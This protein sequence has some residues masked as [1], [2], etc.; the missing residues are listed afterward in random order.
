[1]VVATCLEYRCYG[2]FVFNASLSIPLWGALEGL[3][4]LKPECGEGQLNIVQWPS[5]VPG[6][7]VGV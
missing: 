2:F 1:M 6:E 5:H 4:V 3:S 7:M